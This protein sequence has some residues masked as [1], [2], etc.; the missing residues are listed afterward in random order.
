MPGARYHQD[1]RFLADVGR[2]LGV[3]RRQLDYSLCG[4]IQN[5]IPGG[6]L[7][8]HACHRAIGIDRDRKPEGPVDSAARALWIV[9]IADALDLLAPVFH[10]KRVANLGGARTD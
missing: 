2:E 1:V 6:L 7:E 8:I 3:G 9:E 10:V 4:S 5:L